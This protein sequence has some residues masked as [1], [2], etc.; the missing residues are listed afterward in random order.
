MRKG[1]IVL[2]VAAVAVM[3][4]LPAMAAEMTPT[5]LKV[6]GFYR[7]KAYLSNFIDGYSAPSIRNGNSNPNSPT[8]KSL[9]G[10]SE[11]TNAFVEQRFRVKFEFGTENVKAVWFLES[12]NIWGD[13]SGSNNQFSTSAAG[14][15]Q[16]AG[17]ARNTGGALGGDRI[18]TETKNIYVWFKLPDT[19]LDFTVGLQNQTDAYAG[20][21]YGAADFAGIFMTGKYEP[22]SYKLGIAKL[23]ENQPKNSDD[24]TLY[25][26]ETNFVVAKDAK[27]GVNFYYL[28]DDTQKNNSVSFTSSLS[29]TPLPFN[30]TAGGANPWGTNNS[31]KVY[32]PGINGTFKAGPATLTGFAMYQWGTINYDA[33][34]TA[35]SPVGTKDVDIQAYML[36]LRGDLNVGPGKMFLEGLYLSGGDNPRDKYKAPITLATQDGSPGGNSAFSRTN[37]VMLMAS[38]DTIN[39]SQCLVGCSG[40]DVSSDP[41]ANGRGIWTI[42]TGYAMPFTKQLKGE[43]NL[44]YLSATKR[45]QAEKDAGTRKGDG[46]GT[47]L[48]AAVHYN[49][50]KGLD[51]GLVGAYAWLGDFFNPESGEKVKNA[52]TTYARINYAY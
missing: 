40:G 41:G 31:K 45:L 49:I 5:N 50:V 11:Q 43:A 28:Q 48:N 23:Y 42:A 22:V 39:I 36:D 8:D 10:G 47:E 1:L 24:M 16:Y 15:Q 29:G 52:Y 21:I 46:M 14:S 4:A 51:V 30:V 35:A 7:S 13:A 12:D 26:A 6:S 38:P 2:L 20:V 27:M 19:S 25:V 37:T 3:F 44:S 32:M 17:A 33:Y 9:Y 34:K 18:N